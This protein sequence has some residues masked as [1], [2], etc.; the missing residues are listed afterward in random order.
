M[1][2]IFAILCATLLALDR[3]YATAFVILLLAFSGRGAL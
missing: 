1:I 2:Q 3:H